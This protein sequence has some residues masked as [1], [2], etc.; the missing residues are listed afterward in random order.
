MDKKKHKT[1]G[2]WCKSIPWYGWFFGL[3]MILSQAICFILSHLFAE[4]VSSKWLTWQSIINDIDSKIPLVPYFFVEVYVLWIIFVP[5]GGVIA[6]TKQK[7]EWINFM[8][9]WFGTLIISSFIFAFLPSYLDR[10]NIPGVPGGDIFVY[11][12]DKTGFSWWI[13]KTFL[14]RNEKAWCVCPSFQ[15]VNIIFCYLGVARRKDVHLAHRISQLIITILV[16]MSTVFVKQHFFVDIVIAIIIS[17]TI[18]FIFNIF[19]P[20][21]KILKKCPNFLIVKKLNWANEKIIP[22]SKEN[23]SKTKIEKK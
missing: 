9:S 12:E 15:C 16:C 17:L 20:A 6:G 5:I 11:T 23:K 18:Y 13:L 2:Q 22:L 3:T 4:Y 21:K 14:L 8:L 19:N 7:Q 1:F 10:T